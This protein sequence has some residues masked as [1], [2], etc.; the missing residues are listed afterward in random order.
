MGDFAEW[1]I[2]LNGQFCSLVELHREG[3]AS[4]ACAA[5]LFNYFPNLKKSTCK[6]AATL[7]RRKEGDSSNIRRYDGKERNVT[8]C[9]I[10]IPELGSRRVVKTTTMKT[11]QEKTERNITNRG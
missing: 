3:S 7:I 4:A 11:D 6:L 2:L 10:L 8:K 1:A 5:G 9:R